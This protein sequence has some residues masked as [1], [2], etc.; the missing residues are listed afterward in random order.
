M[1][2]MSP[3][4]VSFFLLDLD[5]KIRDPGAT[6]RL[7]SRHEVCHQPGSEGAPCTSRDLSRVRENVSDFAV[8]GEVTDRGRNRGVE[9]D[10]HGPNG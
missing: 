5:C 8:L 6:A 4:E 3:E 9:G 2:Q 1:D 7:C 10:D